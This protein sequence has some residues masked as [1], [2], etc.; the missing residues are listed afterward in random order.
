M[1][2]IRFAKAVLL[3]F[4]VVFM[5]GTLSA[6]SLLKIKSPDKYELNNGETVPS[7][8]SVVGDRS[9]RTR[10]I[11]LTDIEQQISYSYKD[12]EAPAEDVEEYV[13]YLVSRGYKN[14]TSSHIY[15]ESGE[16]ILT[17]ASDTNAEYTITVTVTYG[18]DTYKVSVVRAKSG[19]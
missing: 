16:L 13:D 6:C 3:I 8:T 18:E 7:I 5:I 17:K 12:V 11:G 15:G 1:R 2:K 14:T 19:Y 9:V 10:K 4:V